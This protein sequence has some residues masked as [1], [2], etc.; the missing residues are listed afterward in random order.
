MFMTEEMAKRV[1]KPVRERKGQIK[2]HGAFNPPAAAPDGD[3]NGDSPFQS[4]SS[5]ASDEG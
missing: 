2:Y 4:S 1:P 5:C 3:N